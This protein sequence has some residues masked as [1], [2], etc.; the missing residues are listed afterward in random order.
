[1]HQTIHVALLLNT[2][3]SDIAVRELRSESIS[4]YM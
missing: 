4:I 2:A 1:M 3:N